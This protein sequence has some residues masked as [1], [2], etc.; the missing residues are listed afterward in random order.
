VHRLSELNPAE[1]ATLEQLL[2]PAATAPATA[3]AQAQAQVS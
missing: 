1:L 3:Q 2:S